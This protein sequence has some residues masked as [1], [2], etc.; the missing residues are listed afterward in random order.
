LPT[1]SPPELVSRRYR[2]IVFDDPM[3][4][5]VLVSVLQDYPLKQGTLYF[6]Y[7]SREY[8][9]LKIRSFIDFAVESVAHAPPPRPPATP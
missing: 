1:P 4:Q 9:P 5:Q 8:V 3:F 6:V 7:V 2:R